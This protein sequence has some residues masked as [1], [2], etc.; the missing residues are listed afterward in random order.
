MMYDQDKAVPIAQR[1]V[2]QYGG[3]YH[4]TPEEYW[5]TT[6]EF[7]LP[8]EDALDSLIKDEGLT[9]EGKKLTERHSRLGTYFFLIKDQENYY[10]FGNGYKD[11][12]VGEGY[13]NYQ[14]E[15][16]LI[17]P[18]S[19]VEYEYGLISPEQPESSHVEKVLVTPE[20]PEVGHWEYTC[21][22]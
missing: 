10:A 6:V 3:E 19:V 14:A 9:V 2:E 17:R 1:L 11:R 15:W 16:Y 18:Y 5:G 20:Q 21:G 13:D 7:I 4:Y 22:Y 12:E 8:S